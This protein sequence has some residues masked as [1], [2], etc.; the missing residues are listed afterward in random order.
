MRLKQY[1]TEKYKNIEKTKII[2]S[3]KYNVN[4]K[5]LEFIG[6][7]KYGSKGIGY[8]F[9]IMDPKHG[10]YKSTKMEFIK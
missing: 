7:E 5:F 3:K 9:N 6:S 8:Y 4:P 10:D 1:L 2:I